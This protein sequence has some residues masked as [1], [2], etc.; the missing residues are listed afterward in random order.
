MR[1]RYAIDRYIKSLTSAI[2]GKDAGLLLLP[3]LIRNDPSFED[4]Q[5]G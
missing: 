1:V 5:D 4:E 2:E 3:E